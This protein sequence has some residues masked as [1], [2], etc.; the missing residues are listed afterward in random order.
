MKRALAAAVVALFLGACSHEGGSGASSASPGASP[1]AQPT[2]P[3]AF[4]LYAP[5]TVIASRSWRQRVGDRAASG[6]EVI[7]ESPA[8]LDQLTSWIHGLSANPPAGYDVSASGSGMESAQRHAAELGVDFQIFT[9][10]VDGKP[11]ALIVVALDPAVFDA[12][13]G[14]V[15]GW[16]DKYQMLPRSL[17]EPIDAQAKERTGFTLSQALDTSTPIGAALAAAQKLRNSGQRGLVL[18]DAV[19]LKN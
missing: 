1:V 18:I 16:I 13:A 15:L 19:K 8:S 12:K 5:S 6:Q 4:P 3:I 9:H 7:A 11:H 17:R 2:S 10:D 14:P